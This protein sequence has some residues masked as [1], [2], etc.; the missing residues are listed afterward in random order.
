[1]WHLVVGKYLKLTGHMFL[2]NL[3]SML[4]SRA[5]FWLGLVGRIIFDGGQF[6]LW[7][8]FFKQFPSIGG[9]TIYDVGLVSGLY[10][11]S[12]AIIDVF[13]G[14]VMDLAKIINS[15]GLDY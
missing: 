12:F 8:M 7:F 11:V 15:G 10:M 6:L 13:F 14:G 5:S 2:L 3:S 4:S 1:M 9:W